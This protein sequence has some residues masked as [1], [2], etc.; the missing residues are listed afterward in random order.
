MENIMDNF[1]SIKEAVQ[2]YSASCDGKIKTPIDKLFIKAMLA[3][4]MIPMG[5]AGSRE[6]CHAIGNVGLARLVAGVL[7]P[8]GLMMVILT[9][10]E[11]FTGDCLMIV[12]TVEKNTMA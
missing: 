8:V 6:A 3:G 11:L 10:A 5:A 1:L 4:M 12:A 2:R 7:F 9:G